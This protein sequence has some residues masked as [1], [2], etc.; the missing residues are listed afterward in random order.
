MLFLDFYFRGSIFELNPL[1]RLNLCNYS[2]G[3]LRR[4]K[5]QLCFDFWFKNECD[6]RSLLDINEHGRE[7]FNQKA[8]ADGLSRNNAEQLPLGFYYDSKRC[9][10]RAFCRKASRGQSCRSA[11]TIASSFETASRKSSLTTKYLHSL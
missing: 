7:F 10:S 2:P 11:F 4:E 8:I 3:V 1:K 9:A 5:A 6:A